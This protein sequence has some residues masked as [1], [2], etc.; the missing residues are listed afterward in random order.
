MKFDISLPCSQDS[1]P[2]YCH[3][4]DELNSTWIM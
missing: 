1:A 4:S 3:E 2:E